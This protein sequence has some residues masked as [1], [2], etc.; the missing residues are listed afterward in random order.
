MQFL[1]SYKALVL[2]QLHIEPNS[3]LDKLCQH[4]SLK[5]QEQITS[6]FV[7]AI[8]LMLASMSCKLRQ[9][10]IIFW[11]SRQRLIPIFFQPSKSMQVAHLQTIFTRI[12]SCWQSTSTLQVQELKQIQILSFPPYLTTLGSMLG[13]NLPKLMAKHLIQPTMWLMWR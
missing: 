1:I 2:T 13:I 7:Q 8:W 10:W 12:V 3:N 6:I 11:S 4:S 9:L 5:I